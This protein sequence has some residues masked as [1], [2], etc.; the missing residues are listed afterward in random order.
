[1]S[2]KS[3]LIGPRYR[4]ARCRPPAYLRSSAC[5]FARL[6]PA[7]SPRGLPRKLWLRKSA[8]AWLSAGELVRFRLFP[9][10][11]RTSADTIMTIEDVDNVTQLPGK[12]KRTYSGRVYA[13]GAV[14]QGTH[15]CSRERRRASPRGSWA[16]GVLLANNSA[17]M[18]TSLL[19]LYRS[20]AATATKSQST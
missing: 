17:C 15:A 11:A 16:R 7:A 5:T 4:R 20:P 3:V 12:A 6:A 9:H 8:D 10:R 18:P 13:S 14:E 2:P 19:R 1:M